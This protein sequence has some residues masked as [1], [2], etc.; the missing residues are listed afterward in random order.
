MHHEAILDY[1]NAMERLSR[2]DE[3]KKIRFLYCQ[4]LIYA[5]KS[6]EPEKRKDVTDLSAGWEL[7]YVK[8]LK[9]EVSPPVASIECW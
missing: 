2:S 9:M 4:E 6:G 5:G 8:R 1:K 7:L 3:E